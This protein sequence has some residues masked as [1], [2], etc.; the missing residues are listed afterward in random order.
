M[1]RL[2]YMCGNNLSPSDLW[3]EPREYTWHWFNSTVYMEVH[4]IALTQTNHPISHLFLIADFLV[5][6]I[7]NTDL[8]SCHVSSRYLP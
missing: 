7:V 8:I 6:R 3:R 2:E 1:L 5:C 4:T